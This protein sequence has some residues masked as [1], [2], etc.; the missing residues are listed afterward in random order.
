MAQLLNDFPEDLRVVYRHFPLVSIH[1]KAALGTQAA[2]AAGLQGQFWEMHDLLF[3]KQAEWSGMTPEEFQTWVVGQAGELGLDTDQFE[4]D[5]TSDELANMAQDAWDRGRE[6]ELRGTPTLVI[7]GLEYTGPMSYGNLQAII[8]MI[9]LEPQQFTKCPPDL[10]DESKQ[11]TATIVTEKGDI[12]VELYPE[13]APMAVNN[14]VFLAEQD[15]YDNVTFHRVLPN[16][17]A[18]AGDPSGTGYGGPGYAFGIET[19][20]LK[21][22]KAGV[23]AMAN[24]GPDSNGSQFFITYGPAEHLDGGYTIF[25]QVVEGMDVVE[26]ITPRDPSQNMNLPP[27]DRILDVVIEEN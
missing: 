26:D 4:A 16:F 22:D 11:Y 10:V 14:F 25:G 1:D 21:F 3:E 6:V 17:M 2:E 5:M 19:S 7:N 27:G 8:N 18:Q 23:L 20:D 9:L 15:W 12:V 13:A 24:A